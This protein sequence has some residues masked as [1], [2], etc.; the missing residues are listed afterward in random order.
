MRQRLLVVM[1]II[2]SMTVSPI[3]SMGWGGF[4]GCT[5]CRPA[6]EGQSSQEKNGGKTQT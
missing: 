5:L 2:F 4:C 6:S 3:L 1:F